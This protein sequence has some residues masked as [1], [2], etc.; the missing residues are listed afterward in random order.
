MAEASEQRNK[1]RKKIII[2]QKRP[3]LHFYL[4]FLWPV[5]PCTESI[6][7]T[8][9]PIYDGET[10]GRKQEYWLAQCSLSLCSD[11]SLHKNHNENAICFRSPALGC[12][13]RC[14]GGCLTCVRCGDRWTSPRQPVGL[15]Y[16]LLWWEYYKVQSTQQQQ[17]VTVVGVESERES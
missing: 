6:F 13:W 15:K 11:C 17:H 9:F 16:L 4:I 2:S 5:A 7:L 3:D 8:Q 1:L 12:E 10:A 14:R